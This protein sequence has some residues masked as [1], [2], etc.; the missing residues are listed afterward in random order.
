LPPI[1]A[2]ANLPVVN[3]SD[4]K[5]DQTIKNAISDVEAFWRKNYPSISSGTKFPEL[6]GKLY[7]VESN[8]IDL[9]LEQNACLRRAP[10]EAVDNAFYCRL[11]DSV[12]WDRDSRHLISVL[13][14]KY[15]SFLVAVVFAHEFGHAVQNRLGIFDKNPPTIDTESQADCAAGAFIK[16]VENMEAPH[17]RVTAPQLDQVLLG[18]LQV[19]D[20]PPVSSDQISHGNGF[21]RLSAVADGIN[22]GA[23]FC[24]SPT[25]FDR[26]F[27]ERTLTD[28]DLQQGTNEP[29]A[30]VIDA[31]PPQQGG[32]GG[33]GLQPNLNQ[34]WSSAAKTINKPWADVK[35]A[36]ATHPKC[37]ASSDASQFGYCPDDNT[38]YFDVNYARQAYNSVPDLQINK[39]TGDVTVID[40]APGD[41]ALGMLYVYGWGL[42]VRH[43][44]F[45]RSLTDAPAL[46]A[47]SCYAGAYTANI[48]SPAAA[49][50]FHLQPPDMDEAVA[51]V[52]EL[53]GSA[54]AYGDLGTT[55]LDRIDAFDK[56]Y[57][58]G[59]SVC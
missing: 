13:G 31:S 33:G 8:H 21:D 49:Q 30:Q 32:G 11:D 20:P 45:G 7:S 2:N 34:F 40:N 52:I 38:V 24:Y 25:Y 15:G 26:K 46:I 55:A 23:T 14:D 10:N 35:I 50:G 58:N 41:Y 47:A 39:T 1:A 51:A 48:N 17:F 43:Q 4:S 6:R 16:S 42:A 9:A 53:V 56:G 19:R 18:Y 22:K 36:Q 27:T 3:D 44:L 29:F 59:L 12:V 28:Q 57:F 37:G 54:K 5:I